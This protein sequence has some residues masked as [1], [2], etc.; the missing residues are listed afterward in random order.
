[1]EP[2]IRDFAP[3]GNPEFPFS[4]LSLG[5]VL[6]LHCLALVG[7]RGCTG[8]FPWEAA[9]SFHHVCIANP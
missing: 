1:M 6:V 2:L 5:Y 7:G 8:W 9:G 4:F 3:K